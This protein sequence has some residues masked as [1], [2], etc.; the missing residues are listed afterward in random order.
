MGSTRL[1][2]KVLAPIVGRPM[3]DLQLERLERVQTPAIIVVATST[4][5]ADDVVVEVARARG[6]AT[7][8]G[9][10]D[11]VLARF[12]GA[13]AAVDAA[14]IA[15][16]TADCPL[17][18][19]G[20]VDRALEAVVAGTCAYASNTV[21]RT[22]PRGLDIEAFTRAALEVADR[23]ATD[24][25]EREHV[26]PFILRRPELFRPCSVKA[27]A[28]RSAERWTVDTAEDLELVRR[29]Y[30]AL[31]P[32]NPAFSTADVIALLNDH[33]EW[34]AINAGVPQKPAP[35]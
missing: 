33:P 2:G 17:I 31:Y 19:P 23:E 3:L 10:E 35:G 25:A 21:D 18:D 34:R 28:D 20:V 24:P 30:E 27:D 16:T 9:S 6:T 11:D 5:P 1:P 8:R 15:R 7:H 14:V 4:L 13:A 22:Y 32:A 12:A 29:I 26:T